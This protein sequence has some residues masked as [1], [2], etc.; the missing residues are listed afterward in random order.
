MALSMLTNLIQ[1]IRELKKT[2]PI[3]LALIAMILSQLALV[4]VLLK[5]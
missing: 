4:I 2:T 5:G 3:V 1:F